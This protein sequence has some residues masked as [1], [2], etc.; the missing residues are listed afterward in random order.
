M[1]MEPKDFSFKPN[2]YSQISIG[3]SGSSSNNNERE[4]GQRDE[5][6]ENRAGGSKPR[7]KEEF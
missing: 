7:V 2:F 5:L 6:M 3:G 1:L 4:L